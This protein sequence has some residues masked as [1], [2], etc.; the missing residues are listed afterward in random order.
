M[1][2]Q[3]IPVIVDTDPG[4][5]FP[6]ADVDDN[7]AIICALASANLDVRLISVVCGNVEAEE[8]CASIT[9]TLAMQKKTVPVALGCRRPLVR[10]YTSGRKLLAAMGERAGDSL[11]FKGWEM[12]ARPSGPARSA[13]EEQVGLLEK[14][15]GRV[16]ILCLGPLTNVA[17]LLQDRPELGPKIESLVI[18]GGAVDVP[19]NV[20]PFAEFNIWVDPEAA[21]IVFDSPVPKVLVPLDVTTT[22]SITMEE[23]RRALPGTGAFSRYVLECVEG[24]IDVM[25]KRNGAR[26][27][28]PHDPIAFFYLLQPSLFETETADIA[29]EERTGKTSR[30]KNRDSSTAICT[31][32]DGDGFKEAFFSG[33]RAAA[34]AG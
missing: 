8:G 29:V 21:K 33:L 30:R 32:V 4:M 31:R 27:F 26:S 1:T 34:S 3:R 15:S 14:A 19:G 12:D 13:F 22:V 7:L 10:A 25:E 11:A 2:A 28:N 6:Y 18:M 16:T 17:R 5:G 24:W 23:L 9:A 20:S